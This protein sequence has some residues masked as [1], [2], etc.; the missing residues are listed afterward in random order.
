MKDFAHVSAQSQTEPAEWVSMIE[1][2]WQDYQEKVETL[3]GISELRNEEEAE[4]DKRQEL[5]EEVSQTK[6]RL[7]QLDP[8]DPWAAGSLQD[9]EELYSQLNTEIEEVQSLISRMQDEDSENVSEI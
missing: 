6:Q 9:A 8:S 3:R 2:S 5:G 4:W 1:Q 7:A